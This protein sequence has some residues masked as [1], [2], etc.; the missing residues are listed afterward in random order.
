MRLTEEQV[1]NELKEVSKFADNAEKLSWQRKYKKLQ[2][3]IDELK[4]YEEKMLQLYQERMPIMDKIHML[5]QMMV[6]ECIHPK[7]YL[8]HKGTYIHCKFCDKIIAPKR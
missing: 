3:L 7:N 5:R 2:K 1:K 8:T 6:N 4:P